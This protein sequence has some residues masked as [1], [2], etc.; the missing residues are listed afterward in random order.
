VA[1]FAKRK[2]VEEGQ[3][4][5]EVGSKRGRK[6]IGDF[7]VSKKQPHS[8]TILNQDGVSFKKESSISQISTQMTAIQKKAVALVDPT[9]LEHA[10]ALF[11]FA[12]D[13]ALQMER[14]KQKKQAEWNEIVNKLVQGRDEQDQATQ[15]G[16]LTSRGKKEFLAK[17]ELEED[18]EEEEDDGEVGFDYWSESSG[19]GGINPLD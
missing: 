15:F 7:A 18:D 10:A 12:R 1:L 13:D 17:A 5:V 11:S 2:S 4:L 19:S 16:Q 3:P 8:Q 14:M 6:A 9:S